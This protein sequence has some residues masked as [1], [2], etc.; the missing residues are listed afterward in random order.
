V[1]HA[2]GRKHS[3]APYFKPPHVI[4]DQIGAMQ[5]QVGLDPHAAG[6]GWQVEG[7]MQAPASGTGAPPQPGVTQTSPD[8]QTADPHGV[9]V[10]PS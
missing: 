7:G 9:R 2:H 8:V 5:P 1:D 4:C 10:P 6:N 3:R